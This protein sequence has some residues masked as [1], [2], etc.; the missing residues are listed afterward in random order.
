MRKTAR[1]VV[2]EGDGAQS[3]SLDLISKSR[4]RGT[5]SISTSI[6]LPAKHSF[7]DQGIVRSPNTE[8]GSED[9]GKSTAHSTSK[10]APSLSYLGSPGECRR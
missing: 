8:L 3:S 5:G 9:G 10:R 6:E 2:W 4:C 1:P 7:P